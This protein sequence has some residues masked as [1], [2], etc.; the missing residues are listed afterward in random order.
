MAFPNLE[1]DI[2]FISKLPDQPNDVSGGTLS[3]DGLKAEFDKAGEAIKAFLNNTLIPWLEGAD[4]AASLGIRTIS[5]LSEASNIQQA[6]E[7][8]KLAIDNTAAG[9]VPDSS[10]SGDKLT[11]GAV[12]SRELAEG[13]VSSEKIYDR[14]V[15]SNKLSE[16]AVT[17]DKI[18]D[19]CVDSRHLRNGAVETSAIADGAVDTGKIAS[20]AV[21]AAKLAAGAVTTANLADAAV[22]RAKLAQDALYSP[23]VRPV[24]DKFNILFEYIGKTIA[25]AYVAG[26]NTMRT[27]TFTKAVSSQYPDGSDFAVLR[28]ETNPISIIFETGIAVGFKGAEGWLT[29]GKTVELPDRFESVALKKLSSGGTDYWILYGDVEVVS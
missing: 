29:G 10:L 3:A 24:G 18:A 7:L 2:S 22:T 21:T 19:N 28:S 6:L 26:D 25:P 12:G 13:A 14:A 20:S 17:G 1:Q 9:S 15:T 8:L 16:G 11:E 23:L 5:G 4:A 27:I